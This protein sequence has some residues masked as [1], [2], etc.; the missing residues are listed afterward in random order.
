[1]LD[2]RCNECPDSAGLP[3]AARRFKGALLSR[4]RL[5]IGL[6]A[7]AGVLGREILGAPGGLLE[8]PGLVEVGEA[9]SAAGTSLAAPVPAGLSES[10]IRSEW[11][12]GSGCL[13]RS[14]FSVLNLSL[15]F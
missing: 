15:R 13:H 5:Q 2:E 11:Q 12:G 9:E 4:R 1:M 3:H 7:A 8:I 10:T 14:V 6:A